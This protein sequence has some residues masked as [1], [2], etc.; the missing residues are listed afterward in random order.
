MQARHNDYRYVPRQPC[1][2]LSDKLTQPLNVWCVRWT[3]KLVFHLCHDDRSTIFREK[4][5]HILDMVVHPASTNVLIWLRRAARFHTWD[6]AEPLGHAATRPLGADVRA[7][8]PNLQAC[9]NPELNQVM[10]STGTIELETG[11]GPVTHHEQI[12]FRS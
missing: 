7:N 9:A 11:M 5:S 12:S 10:N 8:T 4:R 2:K 1:F 3:T 6:F